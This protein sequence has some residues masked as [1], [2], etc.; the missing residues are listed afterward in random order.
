MMNI[1]LLYIHAK[2]FFDKDK[3]KIFWG[4]LKS[5]PVNIQTNDLNY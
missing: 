3:H 5:L 1:R 2:C 4:A